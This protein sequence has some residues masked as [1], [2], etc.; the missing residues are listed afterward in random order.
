MRFVSQELFLPHSTLPSIRAGLKL[1]TKRPHVL[2]QA[3]E[4]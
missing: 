1:L 2:L 3:A 4:S